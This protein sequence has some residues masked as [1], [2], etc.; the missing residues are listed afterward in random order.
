MAL[1]AVALAVACFACES[2]GEADTLRF[3]GLVTGVK[4]SS[5]L[6]IEYIQVADGEGKSLTFHADGRR[7][8]HFT[9]SHVREHMTQGLGVVVDYR[10]RD[11]KLFIVAIE[12]S[13]AGQP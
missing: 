13:E 7:F 5:L 2:D 6:D 3:E 1:A 11:G 4:S 8:P 10:E 12:D 9:P